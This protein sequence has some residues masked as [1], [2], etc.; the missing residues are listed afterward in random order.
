MLFLFFLVELGENSGLL[1]SG[2]G[3]NASKLAYFKLVFV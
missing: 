1:Q 3:I 2:A